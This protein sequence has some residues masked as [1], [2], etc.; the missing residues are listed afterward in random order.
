MRENI[1]PISLFRVKDGDFLLCYNRLSLLKPEFGFYVDKLGRRSRPNFLISW[2]GI[3]S[4]FSH[5]GDYIVAYSSLFVEIRS[6][7][8]GA[9]VQ[10]INTNNLRVLN[11]SLLHCATEGSNDF[12]HIFKLERA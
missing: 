12:H 8:T 3:P 2:S 10:V 4:A 6:M 9:L 1:K 11:D 5:V 7:E